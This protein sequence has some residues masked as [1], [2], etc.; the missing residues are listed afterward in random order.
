MPS[1]YQNHKF[2]QEEII[3]FLSVVD[4]TWLLGLFLYTINKQLL[5]NRSFNLIQFFAD[6]K[7][8]INILWKLLES[9]S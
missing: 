2:K 3:Y 1:T 4:K 5:I 8:H 7:K 6:K 9:N